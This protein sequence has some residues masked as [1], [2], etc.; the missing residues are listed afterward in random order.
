MVLD[1]KVGIFQSNTEDSKTKK[2]SHRSSSPHVVAESQHA[3]KSSRFQRWSIRNMVKSGTESTLKLERALATMSKVSRERFSSRDENRESNERCIFS[4]QD[5]EVYSVV[6]CVC[7]HPWST[8]RPGKLDFS[9]LTVSIILSTESAMTIFHFG[10]TEKPWW[11]CLWSSDWI[12][13]EILMRVI[14]ELRHDC[15]RCCRGMIMTRSAV[16]RK[17]SESTCNKC[18][19]LRLSVRFGSVF[20]VFSLRFHR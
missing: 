2:G 20:R 10:E 9:A 3:Q 11:R 1:A 18:T 14:G 12:M 16:T 4:R 19:F 5:E 6:E 13:S 8:S 17:E 15:V 7:G